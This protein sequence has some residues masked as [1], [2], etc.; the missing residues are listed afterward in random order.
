MEAWVDGLHFP[1]S[2]SLRAWICGWVVRRKKPVNSLQEATQAW[3][4][5]F[6]DTM[7]LPSGVA[8]KRSAN[9]LFATQMAKPEPNPNPKNNKSPGTRDTS[10]C[11]FTQQPVF[12]AVFGRLSGRIGEPISPMAMDKWPNMSVLTTIA[13]YCPKG[14]A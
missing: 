1:R 7:S 9:L 8:Q 11:F 5:A 6:G 14:N 3:C 10:M 2:A 12:A 13:H 4:R